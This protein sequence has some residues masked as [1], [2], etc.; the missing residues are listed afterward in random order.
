MAAQVGVAEQSIQQT[1][2]VVAA[3]LGNRPQVPAQE[4]RPG[5]RPRPSHRLQYGLEHAK[6]RIPLGHLA[7]ELEAVDR[8]ARDQPVQICQDVAV[9]DRPVSQHPEGACGAVGPLRARYTACVP[10]HMEP[11]LRVEPAPHYRVAQRRHAFRSRGADPI[12]VGIEQERDLAE[13]RRLVHNA[14][15]RQFAEQLGDGLRKLGDD[16]GLVH[17]INHGG[18]SLPP[19]VSVSRAPGRRPEQA[20]DA[21]VV[22]HHL[23]A[24]TWHPRLWHVLEA[25]AAREDDRTAVHREDGGA[26]VHGHSAVLDRVRLRGGFQ[27]GKAGRGRCRD[28]PV[29]GIK[30][31]AVGV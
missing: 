27:D 14:R 29:R 15:C 16:E 9:A 7:P 25:R 6:A 30:R 1:F 11:H 17:G 19:D 2:Q 5:R 4:E 24:V 20:D 22:I 12:R 18:G 31:V 3:V 23:G 13:K 26:C 21:Q 10:P 28:A 8:L